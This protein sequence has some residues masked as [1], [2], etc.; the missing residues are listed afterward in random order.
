MN[1]INRKFFSRKLLAFLSPVIIVII[2][3]GSC[4]V[5]ITE[6]YVKNEINNNS[7]S[8]IKQNMENI[9][10][11]FND[12]NYIYFT[13]GTNP[14][15]T[16]SLKRILNKSLYSLEDAW[17]L[18]SITS[19]LNATSYSKPYIHSIYIYFP[20]KDKKFIASSHGLTDINRFYDKSWLD[21]YEKNTGSNSLW[22][23]VRSIEPYSTMSE[24]KKVLTIYKKIQ[25]SSNKP[26]GMLV[27]NI[28][29]DYIKNLLN[30]STTVPGQKIFILDNEDNI[31]CQNNSDIF[32]D[33]PDI[34]Q[35][36]KNN[37]IFEMKSNQFN[38]KYLSV[39]PRK[40]IYRIPI[41][42]IKLILFLLGI[43]FLIGLILVYYI[44]KKNYKDLKEIVDL[45]GSAKSDV[46]PSTLPAQYKNE[47]SYIAYNI[48][49]SFMQE[50][51]LKIE[52][53]E[54]KYRL[55][56]MQ[57][58]AL[59]SQINPHFLFNTLETVNM[60][61]LALTGRPN[62]VND[63]IVNLS[64]ILKYSLSDPTETITLKDEV[65]NTKCYIYIQKMRYKEKFDL[66]WSCDENLMNCS[67][68]KLLLQPLIEN[69]I[70]HGI[71]E[72]EGNCIIKIRIRKIDNK[73][74]I[75][76]IDNGLGMSAEKLNRLKEQMSKDYEYSEHIGLMNTAERLRLIYG[77]SQSI[78]IR[79]KFGMGTAIYITIPIV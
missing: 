61:T 38:T 13:F 28:Q 11:I 75:A 26:D 42:L 5:I 64:K 74:R 72:K 18:D 6:R 69:S 77:D 2:I 76:V 71:K 37:F 67:V 49:E 4:S 78:L 25:S 15:V 79:S 24:S 70:Y 21:N 59:Q 22:I 66:I 36:K 19:M 51:Y 55:R 9:E 52:L 57:L 56:T 44:T 30:T 63:I 12:M 40:Y 60:K 7:I 43:S 45:I 20:N 35:L 27:L 68:M 17:Q 1:K 48:I 65:E 29:F 39:M 14:N 53:S 47:Y 8:V 50:R 41:M 54:K 58:L 34:N 46:I 16:V 33:K 31:I 23:Q 73:I 32:I 10:L 62:A 3:L